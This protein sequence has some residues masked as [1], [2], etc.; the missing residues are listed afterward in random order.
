MDLVMLIIQVSCL[1]GL[2]CSATTTIATKPNFLIFLTDD[3]DIRLG[4]WEPM[5]QTTTL[6]SEKGATATQWNI[7]TPVCCPSRAELLSG[8]YFHNVRRSVPGGGCMH[9]DETKVNPVS[10][11]STLVTANYSNGYF[12]KHMNQCVRTPPPGYDCPTCWWF[13]NDGGRDAEPGGY[14]NATFNDYTQLQTVKSEHGQYHANTKGEFAGYT[15]SVI[16]NKS[17]EWLHA[18]APLGNPFSLVVA[19]KAPHAPFTPALWYQKGSPAASWIDNMKAPRGPNYN[20]SKENLANFHWLIAQQDI[21]TEKQA[22]Q[23]DQ[24][25]RN[26]LRTLLSVDDAVAGVVGTLDELNLLDNTYVFFTSDHGY[27]LGQHRLPFGK[28][29]VY[30][31]AIRIP[32]VVRGPGI[33]HNST[34]DHPCTNVDIAP[35]LLGLAGMQSETMDGRSIAPLIVDA[36][37]PSVSTTAKKHVITN[38]PNAMNWRTRS[39]V[40]YYS[41]GNVTRLTHL[42][43]DTQ[44]NTYRALRFHKDPTFGNGLYA[45]FTEVKDWNFTRVKHFEFFDLSADPFQL[46]NIYY[47]DQRI[48]KTKRTTLHNAVLKEW[49]C[50]GSSCS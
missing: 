38:F 43:D 3:M 16:A 32:M 50:V 42:V 1:L 6:L 25:F 24:N 2:L 27:N 34:F 5:R 46:T 11:A 9:V 33:A 36:S 35:T 20:A 26:R 18:I 41:L 12:G 31:H 10:F 29:N 14:F 28:H 39:L 13:A 49:E 4:G 47:D 30:D 21:I 22:D 48:S 40:E 19:P 23:I 7:H 45:E 17:I 15:T 37:V 44:S 8:R